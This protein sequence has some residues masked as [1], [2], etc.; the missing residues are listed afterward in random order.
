MLLACVFFS[1]GCFSLFI[2]VQ[3]HAWP[4]QIEL[5]DISVV[6]ER[7]SLKLDATVLYY[8]KS[9]NDENHMLPLFKKKI[10]SAVLLVTSRSHEDIAH[11]IV[12]VCLCV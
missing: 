3:T 10:S 2:T 6:S 8:F 1:C 4:V 12:C 11:L 5:S 9:D 7:T